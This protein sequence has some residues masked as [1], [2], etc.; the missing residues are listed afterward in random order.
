MALPTLLLFGAFTLHPR[1]CRQIGGLALLVMAVT[2]AAG[3]AHMPVLIDC[4][5]D[6]RP[7]APF[8]RRH[9]SCV[10]TL[11]NALD[12]VQL[13]GPTLNLPGSEGNEAGEQGKRQHDD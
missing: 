2:M 5:L 7:L 1:T 10:D 3:Q 6:L 12:Q 4:R 11:F 9:R 13:P 8:R